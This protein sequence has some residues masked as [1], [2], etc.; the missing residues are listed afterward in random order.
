VP[1]ATHPELALA[2]TIAGCL[3]AMLALWGSSTSWGRDRK[4][5][6][7]AM[8][9]AALAWAGH[10]LLESA[11]QFAGI[12][13]PGVYARDAVLQL[14]I[15]AVSFFLLTTAGL[16]QRWTYGLLAVQV[17]ASA[18][19]LHWH[20]G[21]GAGPPQAHTA[22]VAI[23]FLSATGFTMAVAWRVY[24]K[25]E[26]RG[27]LALSGGLIGL[28]VSVDHVLAA[29]EAVRVLMLSQYFYAAFLLV[30]WHLV[31]QRTSAD[32]PPSFASSGFYLATDSGAGPDL[33]A[34]AVAGERRRIAQDLHDGVGSQIV[35]IL[36]SLDSRAPSQQAVALALENC[37]LDLKITVD[38][39]DSADDS[40][41]EALGRL[42][43]RV[44]HSLDKLGIRMDWKVE[45]CAELETIR[46]EP[47]RQALRIAQESICN[48]MRHAEASAVEVLCR[49]L[50]SPDRLM[51][52]VRDNGCGIAGGLSG[53][54]SGKGFTSMHRRARAVGGELLISSRR[55][56]GTRVRFVLPLAHDHTLRA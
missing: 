41:P 45:L 52:E 46:G 39:I 37:L 28:G 17:L 10:L 38:A 25:R 7:G 54:A 51:L 30:V 13:G 32:E 22:W 40:V 35:N 33:A 53:Q 29:D 50:P 55:G 18:V 6:D 34:S 36:S 24:L 2:S 19:A 27:W 31:T 43:Y 11:V 14:L 23:N 48:V 15:V 49:F 47:A 21:G 44:Q 8:S 9:V 5:I 16:P 4:L 20:H 42:R 56:A 12:S 1:A 26:L 3:L